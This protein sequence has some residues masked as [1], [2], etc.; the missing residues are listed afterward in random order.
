MSPRSA[1]H[2]WHCQWNLGLADWFGALAEAEV[3]G[4]FRRRGEELELALLGATA[5]TGVGVAAEESL[6]SRLG[7]DGAA[8]VC[9]GASAEG[10]RSGLVVL[11]ECGNFQTRSLSR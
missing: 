10:A 2:Q 6:G 1:P 4:P 5:E 9:V 7:D 11:A 3:L 8:E